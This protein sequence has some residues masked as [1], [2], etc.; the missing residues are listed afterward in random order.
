MGGRRPP[1]ELRD[2]GF[3]VF[4]NVY[5]LMI[6]GVPTN[7]KDRGA[8]ARSANSFMSEWRSRWRSRIKQNS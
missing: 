2:R 7:A 3:A 1:E 8:E 6:L 4:V 5:L